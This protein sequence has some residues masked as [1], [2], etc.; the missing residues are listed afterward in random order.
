MYNLIYKDKIVQ[1]YKTKREAKKDLDDRA[2]LCYMLRV[3]P[4]EAYLITKGKTHATR[5]KRLE[6]TM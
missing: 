3:N 2:S 1:R 5:R 4:S 6:R